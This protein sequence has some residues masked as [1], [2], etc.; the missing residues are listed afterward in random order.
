[1]S[2]RFGIFAENLNVKVTNDPKVSEKVTRIPCSMGFKDKKADKWVNEWV[3]VV[4][5]DKSLSEGIVKGDRLKV[6]GRLTLSEWTDKQGNTKKSWSI[7]VEE[8]AKDGENP[9]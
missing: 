5:F 3:D 8:L 2:E 1:M 6:S 7:L 9:F 4:V